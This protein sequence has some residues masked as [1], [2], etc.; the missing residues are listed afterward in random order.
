[1]P[2]AES[3]SHCSHRYSQ[4][5]VASVKAQNTCSTLRLQD[6]EEA[7]ACSAGL[8]SLCQ[9]LD[10]PH[11][12]EMMSSTLLQSDLMLNYSSSLAATQ[13]SPGI[14]LLGGSAPAP[15]H[16]WGDPMRTTG[17]EERLPGWGGCYGPW[18]SCDSA[19]DLLFQ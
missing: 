19:V 16:C 3:T 4:L 12:D 5:A 8:V 11:S 15:R 18:D 1:M 13:P 14:V 17:D 9:L 6:S 2:M 10:M 7:V